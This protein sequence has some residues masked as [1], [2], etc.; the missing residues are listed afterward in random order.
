M[1]ESTILS[2]RRPSRQAHDAFNRRF[3]NERNGERKVAALEGLSETLYD[4]RNELVALKRAADED[5]LTQ[6]LRRY[7]PRLFRVCSTCP[8]LHLCLK[9][10]CSRHYTVY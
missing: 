6:F 2:L 3:W 9:S 4:N 10:H 8:C 5:R 7:F 1:M